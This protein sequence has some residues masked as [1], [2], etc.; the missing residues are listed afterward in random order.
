MKARAHSA[1]ARGRSRVCIRRT[2]VMNVVESQHYYQRAAV[3]PGRSSTRSK[4]PGRF[5]DV[6]EG[7]LYA[8]R[9]EGCRLIDV[10]GHAYIDTLSSLGAISL[11]YGANMAV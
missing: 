5:F 6:G 3:I 7:P 11:G 2:F 9:G 10:D 1:R 4:A 8:L